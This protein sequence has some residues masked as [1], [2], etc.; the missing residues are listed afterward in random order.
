MLQAWPALVSFNEAS[1]LKLWA[2]GE[3]KAIVTR[4]VRSEFFKSALMPYDYVEFDPEAA[5]IVILVP[6]T[7]T[8]APQPAGV[9][10]G[11]AASTFVTTQPAA[12]TSAP[13]SSGPSMIRY[14]GR[15]QH[16]SINSTA[17]SIISSLSIY[18][19]F[20]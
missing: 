5:D 8:I 19:S 11:G 9:W 13:S 18:N 2:G 17:S 4:L 1:K 12:Q 15:R 6:K 20:L 7:P 10:F 14:R 3:K 16:A